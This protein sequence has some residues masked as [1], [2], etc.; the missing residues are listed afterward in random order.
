MKIRDEDVVHALNGD[1]VA[2]DRW[3]ALGDHLV[4]HFDD[5]GRL[6]AKIIEDDALAASAVMF[7]RKRGQIHDLRAGKSD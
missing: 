5:T 3:V 4:G 1:G 2:L 6:M 7:L